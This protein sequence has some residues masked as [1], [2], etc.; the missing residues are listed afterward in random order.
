MSV[1]LAK[2]RFY[3][4]S[5]L[6]AYYHFNSDV[7]TDDSGN[8]YTLTNTGSVANST[9]KFGNGAD[10]G[11]SNTTKYLSI[12]SD[13]GISSGNITFGGW[14]KLNTEITSSLWRILYKSNSTISVDQEIYYEYNAGTRRL[15]WM[16]RKWGSADNIFYYN[17]ALGTSNWVHIAYTYDGA[18]VRGY[19]N[20]KLVGS[21]A[22]SGNGAGGPATAFGV[23]IYPSTPANFASA[24]FDDVAVWNRTLS[25]KEIAELYQDTYLGKFL[26][27]SSTKALYHLDDLIDASDNNKT[28]T[29]NNSVTFPAG[30][31]GNC[32]DFGT[33]NTNK[34]LT[35]ADN[36]GI[37]GGNCTFSCWVKLNSEIAS[38]S[39]YFV[40]NE[41]SVSKTGCELY[42]DYNGGARRMIAF[43]NKSGVGA[44]FTTYSITL[45]TTDW[46]NLGLVFDGSN[47]K[48]YINGKLVNSAAASGTGSSALA[49]KTYLAEYLASGYAS[50]KI[51]ETIIENRAWTDS[52]FSKYYSDIKCRFV[53]PFN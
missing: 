22:S 48:L 31:L 51:D 43:R 15:T 33:A 50:A 29:N 26:P 2:S 20:G 42:Y 23:G 11:A 53:N 14:V 39:W 46:Y 8:G 36:L 1:E 41:S 10:L 25:N 13:L 32:A 21:V 47:I 7:I 3:R 24:L 45:G 4:E 6:R 44:N 17:L 37:D 12:A 28:L 30:F 49:S 35:I 16:R 40:V 34:S 52:E 18:T 38:S 27:T 5:N 19:V 9:A